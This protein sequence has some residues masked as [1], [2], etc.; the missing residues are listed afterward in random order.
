MLPTDTIRSIRIQTISP[1]AA[2]IPGLHIAVSF[3]ELNENRGKLDAD[4]WHYVCKLVRSVVGTVSCDGIDGKKGMDH[5]SPAALAF[6]HFITVNN[7]RYFYANSTHTLHSFE[8]AYEW[9]DVELRPHDGIITS[10][11]FLKGGGFERIRG[12]LL[13][14]E[15]DTPLVEWDQ[16]H[17]E[18]LSPPE[19]R[20]FLKASHATWLDPSRGFH[21]TLHTSLSSAS[22]PRNYCE[23]EA[24]YVLPSDFFAD[25]YQ[26][27]DLNTAKTRVWVYGETDL[28]LP[29]DAIQRWGSVIRV[30]KEAGEDHEWTIPIHMR[31]QRLNDSGESEVRANAPLVGWVC[32]YDS[33]R[34]YP[35]P[36]P[37]TLLL[38][39]SQQFHPL[40]PDAS[41]EV[42]IRVPTGRPQDRGV[43]AWGTFLGLGL[44]TLWLS[45]TILRAWTRAL[46]RERK[47]KAAKRD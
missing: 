20:P 45:Y 40:L 3:H 14:K 24:I 42:R 43:I 8:G 29:V 4:V 26:L 35:A 12:R 22:P 25:P 19:N 2:A 44:A 15:S 28:E 33:R 11:R 38:S 13:H 34:D 46:R 37:E 39:P 41:K 5:S 17:V 47:G 16:E 32:P 21:P 6:S 36:L 10:H 9:I 30:R 31:Y 1:S 23:L 7:Y 27:R 18:T